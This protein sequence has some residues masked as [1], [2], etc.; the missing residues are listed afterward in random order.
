MSF[1][2]TLFRYQCQVVVS[3]NNMVTA[4]VDLK[5]KVPPVISE[6]VQPIKRVVAGETTELS[7]DAT[8]E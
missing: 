2:T 1:L 5:V 6:D 4:D 8:G 3:L 7:C